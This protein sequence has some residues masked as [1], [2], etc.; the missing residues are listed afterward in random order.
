MRGIR[1][2]P[3]TQTSPPS[4]WLFTGLPL[5]TP[6]PSLGL[7]PL[8][9]SSTLFPLLFFSFSSLHFMPPRQQLL[10]KHQL[11]SP[12]LAWLEE[13]G[14]QLLSQTHHT[15]Y[16]CVCVCM[17]M[18]VCVCPHTHTHTHVTA[19][20]YPSSIAHMGWVGSHMLMHTHHGTDVFY[21]TDS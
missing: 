11:P 6:N 2:G 9:G 7:P 12:P 18:C 21:T 3:K 15:M 19:L 20:S 14:G 16:V 5:T 1:G 10:P 13:P 8:P 17:C 4:P